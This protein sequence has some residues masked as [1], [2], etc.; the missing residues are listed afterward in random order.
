MVHTYIERER[1][2][3]REREIP[4]SILTRVGGLEGTGREG[5]V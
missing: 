4:K 3:E 1:E 5:G 2:R